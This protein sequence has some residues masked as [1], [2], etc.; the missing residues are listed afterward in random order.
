MERLGEVKKYSDVRKRVNELSRRINSLYNINI[1][2]AEE[3][4]ESKFS[5]AEER[6]ELLLTDKN[7]E[8]NL[9]LTELQNQL[10]DNLSDI[11]ELQD[12][13]KELE[14]KVE[15]LEEQIVDPAKGF[16]FSGSF[17]SE[18]SG[19]A[20]GTF[21]YQI[22]GNIKPGA[23]GFFIIDYNVRWIGETVGAN[24]I[25][26]GIVAGKRPSVN[27]IFGI[28][29]TVNSISGPNPNTG[30]TISSSGNI[31]YDN[32]V[33]FTGQGDVLGNTVLASFYVDSAG[34]LW[35]A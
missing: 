34:T 29:V 22:F 26:G 12:E 10:D 4:A 11:E 2:E 8:T 20:T 6:V 13:V 9:K 15:D 35:P 25:S 27:D 24:F 5:Y 21:S 1:V 32:Y 30:E 19:G 33:D 7:L 31:A 23:T 17:D 16:S 3:A 18:N 28:T 14:D